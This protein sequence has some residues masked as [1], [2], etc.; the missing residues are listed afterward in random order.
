MAIKYLSAEKKAKQKRNRIIIT[1]V[2]TVLVI[3]AIVFNI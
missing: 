1:V 3:T 2:T